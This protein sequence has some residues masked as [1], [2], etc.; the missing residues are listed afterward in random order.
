M[1]IIIAILE[2]YLKKFY[3]FFYNSVASIVEFKALGCR[4]RYVVNDNC[5]TDS[6]DSTEWWDKLENA[7]NLS[8]PDII[9]DI[10]GDSLIDIEDLYKVA[11]KVVH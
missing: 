3:N 8:S 1:A 4:A 7:W 5:S 9:F 10:V 6:T 2:T 11:S